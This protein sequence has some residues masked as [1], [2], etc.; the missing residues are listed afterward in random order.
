MCDHMVLGSYICNDC[1]SELL[2]LS[3]QWPLPMSEK[4][5]KDRITLFMFTE[6][7][8]GAEKMVEY[9]EDLREYIDGLRNFY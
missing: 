5:I 2:K 7:V 1:R 6:K 3:E 9:I 4:E 8:L